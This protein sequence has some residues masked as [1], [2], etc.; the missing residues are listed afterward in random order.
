MNEEGEEE[1]YLGDDE[2]KKENFAIFAIEEEE[3]LYSLL[4]ELKT[5]V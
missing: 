2:E 4:S 3:A 5:D 1:I